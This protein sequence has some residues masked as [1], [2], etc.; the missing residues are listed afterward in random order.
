[1]LFGKSNPSGKLPVTFPTA[2]NQQPMYDPNCTDTSAT[3]NCPIYP[4]TVGPSPFLAG[5]TTSWR[6][7]TGMQVN[8]IYEGYRWY[9]EHGVAPL[10]P[11]GYGLSYTTFGYSK[12]RVTRD[13]GAGVDVSF[14]ITNTGSVKGSDVPQVYVG[15]SGDLPASIQQAVRK[16]VGFQ[17]VTL[18]A[19]DSQT[20]TV[21]VGEQQLSS[22]ASTAQRWLV[23]TGSRTMYVGSSSRDLRLQTSFVAN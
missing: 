16:L 3:G 10:F 12:L 19:G 5:S 17:R 8:G 11:F 2:A 22:W 9:D 20:M 6:T 14:T 7:I 21:H 18:A 13:A 23:G 15:S 1:V 4:G